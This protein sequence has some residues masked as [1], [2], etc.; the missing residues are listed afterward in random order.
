MENLDIITKLKR[1]NL[2]GRSG[3]GFPTGFKWEMVKKE[4]AKKK[5]IVCNAASGEPKVMKDEYILENHLPEVINGIKIALKTIDKS[6]GYIYLRKDFYQKFKKPLED[7]TKNL[8]ITLF[9]KRGGYLA[10]EE[11]TLCEVIEGKNPEPRIKPPFPV[12][13]GLFGCP[14]LINNVET[15]YYIS[16][17]SKN[18]YKKTRFYTLN[19]EVQN[20]GVYE[21]P[22]NWSIERIL[23]ETENFPDFD[24][25]VQAGGGASGEILL[26]KE[27]KKSVGGPGAIIVFNRKET[28]L[29][30]L[31]KEWI[32]FFLAENC[33]KCVPCREG[34][35]RLS[36]MIE[37]GRID[38]KLLNDLEFVL[39]ETSF[40][41]LGKIASIPFVGVINKLL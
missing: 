40:C 3:S 25:F 10:G 4:K 12:Q 38:R 20:K 32:S 34:V 35:Y 33:D 31:M 13:V 7:L 28:D 2:L 36:E 37:R 19:G 22:I 24:F 14:T 30:S 11:T 39:K 18:Q 15:F 23:K 8:P 27:L 29:Y 9:K 26:K 41:G 17:I 5:Y 1:S 6:S 21:L 16:K